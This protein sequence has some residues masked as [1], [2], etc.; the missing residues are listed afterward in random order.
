MYNKW[1]KIETKV[2]ILYVDRLLHGDYRC[3]MQSAI[4]S[5]YYSSEVIDYCNIKLETKR[6]AYQIKRQVLAFAFRPYQLLAFRG[7]RLIDAQIT[8][9]VSIKRPGEVLDENEWCMRIATIDYDVIL[10]KDVLKELL[11]CISIGENRKAMSMCRTRK[12]MNAQD[13]EGRT[14]LI[15]AVCNNNFAMVE[16]LVQ[17]GADVNITSFDQTDLLAYAKESYNQYGDDA[18]L[19][20]I[21]EVMD[22]NK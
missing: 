1:L 12:V 9:D 16:Y 15:V 22:L 19:N 11:E 21:C 3:N 8:S 17:H 4:G 20:Y 18:I 13:E 2:V 6:T 10:Y 14:P 7:C 5:T